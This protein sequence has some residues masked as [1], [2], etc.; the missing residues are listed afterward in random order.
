MFTV[1]LLDRDAQKLPS[2]SQLIK[3]EIRGE[4]HSLQENALPLLASLID[5]NNPKIFTTFH[6][7]R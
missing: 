2:E 7:A 3:Q 6:F 5:P 1:D 4:P